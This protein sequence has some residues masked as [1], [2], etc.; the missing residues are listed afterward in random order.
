M[1]SAEW[2]NKI[3][4]SSRIITDILESVKHRNSVIVNIFG[5]PFSEEFAEITQNSLRMADPENSLELIDDSEDT[6]DVEELLF[7]KYCPD[8]AAMAYF[9]TLNNTKAKFVAHCKQFRLNSS[10][11][12]VSL[13]DEKRAGE[14]IDF[15]REYSLNCDLLRHAVFVLQ[16]NSGSLQPVRL[17]KIT[18]V[19]AKDYITAYDYYVYY[20]LE[21]A[22]LY[23]C[24]TLKKQYIAELLASFC[25][26]D[27]AT[28]DIMLNRRE[29]ILERPIE[30]YNECSGQNNPQAE[31]QSRLWRAQMKVLFPAIEDFRY[32]IV[33]KYYDQI[34]KALPF[35]T[36]YKFEISE[37]FEL[38]LGNILAM[39]NAGC[40]SLRQN[41]VE[42]IHD[43]KSIRDDLAHM[44][45]SAFC[46][47]E[48]LLDS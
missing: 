20:M 46:N 1:G 7:R 22:E 13:T 33:R 2:W 15:I 21:T 32:Y 8:D 23:S 10:T 47:I 5:A 34:Q 37:A 11:A 9:P 3:N 40:I 24:S 17:K 6:T 4:S 26:D 39:N 25:A 19:S 18:F 44:R 27:V 36:V 42:K 31:L 48:K 38:D 41:D 28:A 16:I 12:W 30:L 45:P 14:W 43:Y 29:E 35:E